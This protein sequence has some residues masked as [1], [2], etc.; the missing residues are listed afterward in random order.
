[1]DTLQTIKELAAEQFGAALDAIDPDAKVDTFGMDSLG[2]L[3][4]LFALEDKLKISIPQDAVAQVKTL[5]ELAVV[6]DGVIAAGVAAP[7][8]AAS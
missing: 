1:M 3:E 6:I 8:P 4:F 7:P 2:F 5:R